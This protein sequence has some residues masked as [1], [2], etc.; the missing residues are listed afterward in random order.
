VANLQHRR[1]ILPPV[2]QV[3]LILV[4]NNGNNIRLLRPGAA[5]FKYF[6]ILKMLFYPFLMIEDF[7]ICFWCRHRWCT[8]QSCEYRRKSPAWGKLIHEKKTEVG[9]LVTLSL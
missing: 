1:Q 2:L 7:S 4:A 6:C 9:N 8:L 3:L 5:M